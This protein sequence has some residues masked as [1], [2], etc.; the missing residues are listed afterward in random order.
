[1]V[2]LKSK[3]V[4]P[5]HI[6][7]SATFPPDVMES[8]NKFLPEYTPYTVPIEALKLKVIN[9]FR[10]HL[11]AERTIQFISEIYAAVGQAQTVS[12]V[13]RKADGASMTT[14]LES[15]GTPAKLRIGKLEAAV[16]DKMID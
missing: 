10:L 1:M 14:R 9:M 2:H 13:N 15:E 11:N 6:L 5:Q 3:D 4:I 12:V 16:R 8:I 7:F